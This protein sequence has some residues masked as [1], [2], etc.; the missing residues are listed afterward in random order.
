MMNRLFENAFERSKLRYAR[1]AAADIY[2]RFKA[3]RTDFPDAAQFF[4]DMLI[5]LG[6][7]MQRAKRIF[8]K[9]TPPP[10][11]N[12]PDVMNRLDKFVQ[13]HRRMP[14]SDEIQHIVQ[15]HNA[16]LLEAFRDHFA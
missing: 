9:L 8:V 5:K 14:T 6:K 4:F 3:V 2:D 13:A 15:K 11:V 10:D 1:Q 16:E 7:A 12:A